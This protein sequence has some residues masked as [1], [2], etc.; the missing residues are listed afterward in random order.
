MGGEN[1]LPVDWQS[2]IVSLGGLFM[3][4]N[5]TYGGIGDMVALELVPGDVGFIKFITRIVHP[6]PSSPQSPVLHI[7]RCVPN[8]IRSYLSE[9]IW[10]SNT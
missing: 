1:G 7:S 4:R 5:W 8:R 10:S 2:E 3:S 9:S 6:W